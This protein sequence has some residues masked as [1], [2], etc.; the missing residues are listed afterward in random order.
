MEGEGDGK[1]ME[2]E[3]KGTGGRKERK[4]KKLKRMIIMLLKIIII[5]MMILFLT[6]KPNRGKTNNTNR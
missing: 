2:G 1:K 6:V 3:R 5:I 4:K